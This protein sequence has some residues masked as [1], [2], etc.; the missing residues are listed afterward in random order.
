MKTDGRVAIWAFYNNLDSRRGAGAG[1]A[2]MDENCS[3]VAIFRVTG[4]QHRAFAI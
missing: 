4:W 3:L 1:R 2:S